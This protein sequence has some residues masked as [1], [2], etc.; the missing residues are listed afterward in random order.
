[1]KE[2]CG[3]WY[4]SL[5]IKMTDMHNN[6]KEIKQKKKKEQKETNLKHF[7]K[8]VSSLMHLEIQL[9]LPI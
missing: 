5:L 7:K 3:K 4:Y 2:A 6:K 1:M 8:S 9:V